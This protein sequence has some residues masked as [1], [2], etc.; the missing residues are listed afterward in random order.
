MAEAVDVIRA[1]AYSA[2]GLSLLALTSK[3]VHSKIDL[4]LTDVN[5]IVAK[6]DKDSNN[7]LATDEAINLLIAFDKNNDGYLSSE[8]L[9]EA[10]KSFSDL[11]IL[12]KNHQNIFISLR[13][14]NEAK[15]LLLKT[16]EHNNLSEWLNKRKE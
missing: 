13:N 16:Q 6:Y 10:D 11:T 7:I 1:T 15:Q 12:D 14:F 8:E 5:P 4:S 2:L 3:V 9:E